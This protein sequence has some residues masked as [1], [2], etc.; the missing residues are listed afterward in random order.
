MVL[1]CLPCWWYVAVG[2]W[3]HFLGGKRVWVSAV[4]FTV[5]IGISVLAMQPWLVEWE[6]IRKESRTFTF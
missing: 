4:L 6:K 1:F 2:I 5:I 3:S